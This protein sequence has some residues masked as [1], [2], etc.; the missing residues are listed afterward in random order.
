MTKWVDG[1]PND[2]FVVRASAGNGAAASSPVYVVRGSAAVG[3]GTTGTL[4]C[5]QRQDLAAVQLAHVAQSASTGCAIDLDCQVVRANVSCSQPCGYMV[6]S[7][8]GKAQLDAASR[9]IDAGLCA[10]YAKDGCQNKQEDAFCNVVPAVMCSAG[11][12]VRVDPQG[13]LSCYERQQMATAQM[14]QAVQAA[15]RSC[16]LDADCLVA[17]TATVCADNCGLEP[18][19]SQ[20][21]KAVIEAVVSSINGGLCASFSSDGC[22]PAPSACLDGPVI[23]PLGDPACRGGQCTRSVPAPNPSNCTT[24]FT[25]AIDWGPGPN[26]GLMPSVDHSTLSPCVHYTHRRTPSGEPSILPL[27]CETDFAACNSVASSGAVMSALANPDVQQA[28]ASSPVA[29][30]IDSQLGA[31]GELEIKVGTRVIDVG[32]T[33]SGPPNCIPVPSGVQALVDLLRAIDQGELATP[34]CKAFNP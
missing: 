20:A 1:S 7:S 8:E 9:A 33:C 14:Q 17:P 29:Y 31:A 28:L 25:E 5:Q 12:C 3:G 23:Q 19:A 30:G 2:A 26:S 11:Q 24:C 10:S 34:A 18:V 16:N 13:S 27:S 21:G 15:D 6:V 32:N 4:S 22:L